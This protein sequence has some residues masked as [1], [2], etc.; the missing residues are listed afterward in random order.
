MQ[1]PSY[2]QFQGTILAGGTL[3]AQPF[4]VEGYT[5]FGLMATTSSVNGTLNF[6]VNDTPDVNSGNWKQVYGSTGAAVTV[7]INSGKTAISSD[8][9]T[10]LHGYKYLHI[11]S[12]AQP[13]GL[14]L[15]LTAK[16]D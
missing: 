16:A 6:L 10:S 5:T 11:K 15:T 12:T 14:A 4:N 13:N 8:A 2:N 9:L 7:T 1:T 3:T